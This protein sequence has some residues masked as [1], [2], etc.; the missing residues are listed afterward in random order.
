MARS[1]N[2]AKRGGSKSKGSKGRGLPVLSRMLSEMISSPSSK[3]SRAGAGARGRKWSKGRLVSTPLAAGAAGLKGDGTAIDAPAKAQGKRRGFRSKAEL[4]ATIREAAGV[5]LSS[6]RRVTDPRLPA[7]GSTILKTYK[8]REL[9]VLVG[10]SSFT[11]EGREYP[12]LS[13]IARE[14]IGGQQVNGFAFFGL[15]K[16]APAV[17]SAK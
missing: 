6:G 11:F 3:G 4:V 8:G 12:S 14:V 2:Q 1:K 10:P 17:G 9:S 5:P 15:V 13:K 7:A 16:K